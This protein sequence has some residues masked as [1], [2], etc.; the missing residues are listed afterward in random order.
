VDIKFDRI[1]RMAAF[2]RHLRLDLKPADHFKPRFITPENRDAMNLEIQGFMFYI[3]C[4]EHLCVSP[5][6]MLM[7]TYAQRSK[8]IGRVEEAPVDMLERAVK[9]EG[10]RSVCAMYPIS[11]EVRDWLVAEA[12]WSPEELDP[13]Y[14]AL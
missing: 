14:A 11:D 4:D 7:K 6:L 8:T 9:A 12:D 5:R 2:R 3:D 10:V 13:C 1:K